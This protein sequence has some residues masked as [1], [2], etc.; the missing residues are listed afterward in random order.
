MAIEHCKSKTAQQL[1][2][3]YKNLHDG[4]ALVPE[5]F[6]WKLIDT[7]PL[8]YSHPDFA[9]WEE[10]NSKEDYSLVPDQS[11]CVVKHD[12]SYVAYKIYEATGSWPQKKTKEEIDAKN[13]GQFLKEAGYETIVEKPIKNGYF[14]GINPDK[15]E[16]GIVVWYEGTLIDGSVITT[17]YKNKTYTINK[18]NPSD[19]IWI[20]IK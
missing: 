14:V 19:F 1:I 17:T 12:T 13:W 7:Y 18:E 11:N 10:D 8:P 9:N 6:V 2:E 3:K 15:G 16:H 20:K 4:C 5:D